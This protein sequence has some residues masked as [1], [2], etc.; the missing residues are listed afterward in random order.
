MLR[1]AVYTRSSKVLLIWA[2]ALFVS[3]V[4]FNNLADY[5]SNYAF[6]SHVLKMDTTF[7][8]NRAMWRAID[9][10][11]LHHASYWLII[12]VEAAIAVLCWLGGFR[13]L[14][15][16]HDSSRFNRAKGVAIAGLILG[17]ILWFT[18]FI[19]LGGEWFLMWQSQ[20]WNGQEAAFRLVVILGIVLLYLIQPD[21]SADA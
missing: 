5:E 9:S 1:G 18:G 11:P 15:S 14:R 6:V 16:I 19:T 7:P 12:L 13:L 3:L 21:G 20:I 17:I 2:V 8:E 4:V 10:P